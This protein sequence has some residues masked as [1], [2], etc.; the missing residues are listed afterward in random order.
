MNWNKWRARRW[1]KKIY[2]ARLKTQNGAAVSN[3]DREECVA[4]LLAEGQKLIEAHEPE[5]ALECFDMALAMQPKHAEAL[6]K[7]GGALEKLD[8]L[9]EAIAC[10]DRAIEA[11]NSLAIAYL[12]KGGLFNRLA[13]YDEALQCYEQALRTQEKNASREKVA[14]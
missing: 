8:R 4:N 6:V 1:R 12:Q 2:P 7:K 13:R 9:D 5:K 3:D 10:Y 14:A 11:D